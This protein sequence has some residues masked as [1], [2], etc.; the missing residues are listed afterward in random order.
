MRLAD[1]PAERAV[2]QARE[3]E[4]RLADS[5]AAHAAALAAAVMPAAASVAATVVAAATAV[6]DTGNSGLVIPGRSFRLTAE[7]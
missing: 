6:V 1:M 3:A 2:M 7:D 5:V 4:E